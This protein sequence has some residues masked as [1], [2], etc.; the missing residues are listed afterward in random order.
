[1]DNEELA[2]RIGD[3]LD[4][5]LPINP[6]YREDKLQ[7]IKSLLDSSLG[8]RSGW[9]PVS[10]KLPEDSVARLVWCPGRKNR[11]AAN[12]KE[13]KW[14]IF[15]AGYRDITEEVTHWMPLT[16]PPEFSRTVTP[17]S[18]CTECDKAARHAYSDATTPGF[19]SPKCSKHSGDSG[20]EKV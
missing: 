8:D 17:G 20:A 13:G 16:D 6:V 15:G 1:M 7:K 9:I 5:G 12:Y 19:F 3:V 2:K 18:G 10:E 4:N 14:T 11:F